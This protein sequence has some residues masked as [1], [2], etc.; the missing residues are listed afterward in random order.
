VYVVVV[1]VFA[2]AMMKQKD[3]LKI[4]IVHSICFIFFEKINSLCLQS[5]MCCQV[6]ESFEKKM[7]H[8][9]RRY[10]SVILVRQ[11]ISNGFR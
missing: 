8:T 3:V 1:M 11:Q 2:L 5:S 7:V 6:L 10:R 4:G 9:L